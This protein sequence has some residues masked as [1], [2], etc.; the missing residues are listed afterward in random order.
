MTDIKEQKEFKLL[1]EEKDIVITNNLKNSIV[2]EIDKL[3]GSNLKELSTEPFTSI[4]TLGKLNIKKINIVNYEDLDDL[5]KRNKIFGHISK[6]KGNNCILVDSFKNDSYLE[7]MQDLSEKILT[8]NYVF[9]TFK[10][11]K[12]E[13]DKDFYYYGETS[14]SKVVKKGYIYGDCMNHARE[15]VNTPYNYLN[16]S[17]LAQYAKKLDKYENISVRIYNKKEIQD[18]NMGAFL[19]VNK[20]SIEEP[21][22]ILVKYQGKNTFD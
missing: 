18:M 19:G 2:K 6:L 8:E 15:L 3:L 16:A 12:E 9:N 17:D 1:E 22:L 4:N 13:K 5:K 11:K 10:S 21:K 7:I 20:G 14:I